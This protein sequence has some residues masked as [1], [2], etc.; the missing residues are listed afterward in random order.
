LMFQIRGHSFSEAEVFP[1]WTEQE[2][3]ILSTN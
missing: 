3:T 2:R 1:V